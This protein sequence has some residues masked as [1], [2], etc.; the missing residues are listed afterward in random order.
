MKIKPLINYLVI[1]GIEN[2][3]RIPS[4]FL[5]PSQPSNYHTH[6]QVKKQNVSFNVS[7]REKKLGRLEIS[8]T[9]YLLWFQL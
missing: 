1:A 9:I 3:I 7:L 6:L 4:S 8:V 2:I 5:Q